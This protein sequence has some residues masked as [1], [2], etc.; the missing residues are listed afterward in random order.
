MIGSIQGG[1]GFTS[2]A[3]P[4]GEFSVANDQP[5]RKVLTQRFLKK[6]V[7]GLL[8]HFS[9]AVDKFQ[10]PDWEGSVVKIGKFVE[11]VLKCLMVYAS[12]PLPPAR[13]F[14]VDT[15]VNQLRQLS[16][17][18]FDDTVRLSVPRA[19][20]FVYDIA[21]NRG[22]RHDPDE[23]NPNK[24]DATVAMSISSWMLAELLRFADKGNLTPDTTVEM[25]EELV[26]K[27]YPDFENIDGRIYVNFD[28]LSAPD[29][30]LLILYA[31]YPKRITRAYLVDQVRRHNFSKN[32]AAVATSRLTKYIDD[33][34]GNLK[35]RANGR[36]RAA[37]IRNS[38]KA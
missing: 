38:A 29:L 12:L 14:K 31:V 20:T 35:L 4:G 2:F 22:A 9:E 37:E 21:S 23:I 6:H 7:D 11:A 1:K 30:G 5:I 10:E 26:E 28:G 15:A 8:K 16:G 25:V 19:C 24:M 17:S 3:H 33:D 32:A 18:Q 36:Q 13:Q 34:N 27:R